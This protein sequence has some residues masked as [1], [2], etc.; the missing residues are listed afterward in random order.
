M[1]AAVFVCFALLAG[2]AS[3]APVPRGEAA[4]SGRDA[5]IPFANL[6]GVYDWAADGN[7]ALYIEG[8]DRK[9]YHAELLG[10]CID[11]PF[12]EHIGF[13]T[14]PGSGAF[15]RF[16]SILVRG[17][18]C[19]VRSLTR[20]DPPPSRAKH[21]RNAASSTSASSRGAVSDQRRPDNAGSSR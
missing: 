8:I 21:W 12:A 1:R 9:W 6:G 7:H 15:N 20:S 17:Q 2:C 4:P 14:E 11:L 3:S 10:P 5:S 16:S 19:P 13:V 18:Q